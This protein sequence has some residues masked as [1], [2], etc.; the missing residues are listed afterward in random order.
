MKNEYSLTCCYSKNNS[1]YLDNDIKD[2][3]NKL[4]DEIKNKLDDEYKNNCDKIITREKY[5]NNSNKNS[6]EFYS[7]IFSK[8]RDFVQNIAWGMPDFNDCPKIAEILER[9]RNDKEILVIG[10]GNGYVEIYFQKRYDIPFILTDLEPKNST[11][12]KLSSIEAVK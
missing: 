6:Y 1:E 3:E 4:N 11:I 10:A 7:T 8:R 9:I 2:N 12:E 5:F